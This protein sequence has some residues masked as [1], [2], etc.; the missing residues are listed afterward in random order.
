LFLK[1]R[2]NEH[3]KFE[4][5][6]KKNRKRGQKSTVGKLNKNRSKNDVVWSFKNKGEIEKKNEFFFTS[7]YRLIKI[8]NQRLFFQQLLGTCS[9]SRQPEIV[10]GKSNTVV[11]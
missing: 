10:F 11:M 6:T 1:K 5:E 7:V 3:I 2:G 4:K 9:V 8:A